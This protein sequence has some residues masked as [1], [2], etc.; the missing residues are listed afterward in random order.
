MRVEYGN[1]F[2]FRF[3]NTIGGIESHLYYMAKKYKDWDITIIYKEGDANQINRLKKFVRV[4]KYNGELIKC[5]KV[6]FCFNIDIIDKVDAEEYIEVVHGDYKAMGIKPNI[7]PKINK[8]YGVSKQVCDTFK[9][10]TGF[11]TNLAYNP[12]ALDTISQKPLLLVS[13][14]RLSKEKGRE[15]MVELARQL[16]VAKIPYLWLVFTDNVNAIKNPNILYMN[17]TLDILKYLA[18]AD[19]V[20]QLSDNEGYCYTVVESLCVGT[21]VIVS[22]CP[23]FKEIGVKDKENGFI[24]DFEMKNVPINEIKKGLKGFKYTPKEDNWDKILAP[25][26]STYAEDFRRHILVKCIYPYTDM[27][28]EREMIT[29]DEFVVSVSRAEYLAE[30]KVV[31]I[32]KDMDKEK[33]T[34]GDKDGKKLEL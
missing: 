10:V 25:G 19:Y 17:P 22:E 5:K 4:K 8:Y 14:T 34:K 29:G 18:M 32:V 2:Y 31:T 23:V 3:I 16:D 20:I 27:E 15:R 1:V 21:P 12:I 11:D 28:E 30:N 33:H 24:L 13:A 9:E 26:K 7:H 6:F